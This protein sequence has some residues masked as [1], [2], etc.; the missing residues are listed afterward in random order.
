MKRQIFKNPELGPGEI[1]KYLLLAAAIVAGSLVCVFHSSC[2]M[3]SQGIQALGAEE[4]PNITAV[5]VLNSKSIKVDFT[6]EVTSDMGLVSVLGQGQAASLDAI[7]E[8]SIKAQAT[9]CGDK[10]SILYIFEESAQLGVRY[11]LFSQ[12]KDSRGNSLT[13]AI[14]FDGFNDRLPLC[15]LVEVQP[16]SRAATKSSPAESP[17]VIIQA[18]EDG[19]LFGIDLYCAQNKSTFP[20]PPVEVK[21]GQ[22]IALRLKPTADQSACISETGTDLA[23]AKSGR[24]S[25]A[26]RDLYFDIGQKGMST[27][28]DA[29]FLRDKNTKKIMDALTYFTV[30]NGKTS[31]N[32][33]TEI[34]KAIDKKAWAGP[35]SVEGA[36]QKGSSKVKP[37]VR[38]SN[39][40]EQGGRPAA[41]DDWEVSEKSV[42]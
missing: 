21:A 1:I 12:I 17:Y 8:N 10:R 7:G 19:N 14:P 36:V 6:K 22:K 4:S 32:L 9:V 27:S 33:S 37:L 38:K 39:A 35:A 25:P 31:W 28:N 5:N 2:Q 26:W 30:K 29:I 3:T 16:E 20:L 24:A 18:L 11:Q 42:Y 40:L 34:Q 41:K 23:L 15:A 13:F